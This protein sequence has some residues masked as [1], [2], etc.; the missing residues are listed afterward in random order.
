VAV[1]GVGFVLDEDCDFSKSGVET[2]AEGKID[3]TIFPTEGNSWL[4]PMFGE[5]LETFA[6][7]AG[8]HHGEN[9]PHSVKL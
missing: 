1:E 9:V 8:Q 2:I 7:A 4:G 6:L 3:N 5:R